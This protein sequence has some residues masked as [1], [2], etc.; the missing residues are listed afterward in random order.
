MNGFEAMIGGVRVGAP[1]ITTVTHPSSPFW[2]F[3]I[4]FLV[5]RHVLRH[6]YDC[7]LFL[8]LDT[9]FTQYDRVLTRRRLPLMMMMMMMFRMSA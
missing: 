2:T 4:R 7:I 5:A 1:M 8:R 6:I 9:D 3:L